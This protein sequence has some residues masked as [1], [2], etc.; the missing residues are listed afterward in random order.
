MPC[1]LLLFDPSSFLIYIFVFYDVSK[2]TSENDS[3]DETHPLY[4]KR[5]VFT[6]ALERMS[7]LD[8]A[9]LVANVGGIPENNVT[10]KTNYLILGNNDYNPILRGAK[11]GKQKKAEEYKLSGCDIEIIPE[12]VFYEMLEQ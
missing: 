6:G 5:C 3:F 11:S 10:K 4:R 2:I 9:Q 1:S 7:R 8:A 12:S